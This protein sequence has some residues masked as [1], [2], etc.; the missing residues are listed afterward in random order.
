MSDGRIKFKLDDRCYSILESV[1]DQN[2]YPSLNSAINFLIQDYR[3]LQ[4][5]N[6]RLKQQLRGQSDPNLT[7]KVASAKA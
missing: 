3:R 2:L 1:R 4:D 7:P 6:S 5:E